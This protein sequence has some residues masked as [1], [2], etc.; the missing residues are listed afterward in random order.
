M[1]SSH[2]LHRGLFAVTVSLALAGTVHAQQA[3]PPPSQLPN[4]GQLLQQVPRQPETA[5]RSDLDLRMLRTRHAHAQDT[6][7]FLVKRI[8]ITGNTL[9]STR[10]LHALV[11]GSEGRRLTLGQLQGL[12]DR[13]SAAYHAA[14]Y[15]LARAYVPAQ[16]LRDGVVEIDVVE[17]RYGKVVLQNHSSV[18]DKTLRKV[19]APLQPGQPVANR[20]LERSLLLL[21]DVPGATT[22]SV[23]RPGDQPGTSDLV[24]DVAAAPRYTGTIG[25]DDFGNRYTG[26]ARI[27]GS[28]DVNGLLHRGDLLQVDAASSGGGM[29][30][31]Q[32]GYRML[33]DG[34]GTTLRAGVS[35]LH[36]H[37][38]NGLEAL[39]AHGSALVGSLT[40]AHPFIRST[41]GNL[42]GQI[43]FDRKLLKDDIEAALLHNDRDLDVWSATLAGDQRDA[44][45]ITN[46]RLGASRGKVDFTDMLAEVID[47][48]TART[49]G[50]YS[51]YVVSAS[52]LQQLDPVNAIYVG[53]SRQ[54]ASKNLDTSAQ[55]FL[56]GPDTVRGY[57]A[58]ALSGSQGDLLTAE[59]R[60]DFHLP[61]TP[62]RW[63]ATLFADTGRVEVYKDSFAGGVNSGRASGAGIGLHWATPREWFVDVTAS[64][65]IGAAPDLLNGVDSGTRFWV[66]LRKGFY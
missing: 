39:D 2:L 18:S 8:R 42:Y 5:P 49:A 47:Q 44:H 9:L 59:F 58:G 27:S 1:K 29:S 57:D 37:L 28:F 31:F 66:Q 62:G 53:Y 50:E 35:T 24:V 63:Q 10:V 43:E 4:A 30:Y 56:G 46:F 19:L 16:T 48:L 40:L 61:R 23:V 55:F 64:R 45:G 12:A 17:A 22:S 7:A 52:R 34:Q 41:A 6:Q 14:G 38:R 33:L 26:R 20:P 13:I 32:G 3:V 11:S 21:S 25:A 54:W 60:H 51:R 36:Y 15:P 65:P